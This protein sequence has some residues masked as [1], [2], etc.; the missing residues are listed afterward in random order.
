MKEKLYTI[1]VNEAFDAAD[2]CPFCYAER[3]LKKDT[4]DF[5]LGSGA[6]Y[7][8][9]DFRDVTD[10][11]GFCREHF[12]QLFDYG[13]TLGN[14]W[15][16]KTHYMKLRKEYAELA[17]GFTPG[18]VSLADRI[19]KKERTGNPIVGWID[20]R[21]HSCYA[22]EH[23]KEIFDRYIDTF[24]VLWKTDDGFVSKVKDSKGFCLSHLGTLC[25]AADVSLK[26]RELQGFYDIVLPLQERN[27]DRMQE[28]IDW[29]IEKFDYR[30]ADADWKNSK[31]AL[32]RGMQKLKSGY[33]ADKAYTADR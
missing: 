31:D 28:D 30:N 25:A 33:P 17:R 29:L 23:I 15:I 6:S 16:L 12:K 10:E 14:A 2:E 20:K 22:C 26:D 1:P 27:L 13:N 9:S 24:F 8:E 7:M 18:K 19:M 4:L 21:E 5:V 3:E 11:K 32:Q